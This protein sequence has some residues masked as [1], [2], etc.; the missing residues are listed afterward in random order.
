MLYS[1]MTVQV[2]KAVELRGSVACNHCRA[3]AELIVA[4]ANP[5]DGR[6]L[7]VFRCEMRK[8]NLGTR[9]VVVRVAGLA[10]TAL[11]EDVIDA[12]QSDQAR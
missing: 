10:S 6:T 3:S 2:A 11:F 1:H 12:V 9:I 8:T 4:I 5:K 7:R